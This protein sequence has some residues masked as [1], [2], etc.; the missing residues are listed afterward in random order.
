MAEKSPSGWRFSLTERPSASSGWS[1]RRVI[2]C[3]RGRGRRENGPQRLQRPSS[4]GALGDALREPFAG[5]TGEET[6]LAKALM[7]LPFVVPLEELWSAS[8]VAIAALIRFGDD[9][10]A[11]SRTRGT[12]RR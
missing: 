9:A 7:Q 6:K 2:R 12:R 11:Q 10:I 5:L 3:W 4:L 8:G 1:G